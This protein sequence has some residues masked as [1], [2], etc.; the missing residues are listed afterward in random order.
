MAFSSAF[1]APVSIIPG[2]SFSSAFDAAVDI[3]PGTSFS[4]AFDA[5]V[6]IKVAGLRA[7]QVATDTLTA[8]QVARVFAAD[9]YDATNVGNLFATDSFTS[10]NVTA[11]FATDSITITEIDTTGFILTDGSNAFAAAQSMGGFKLTNL[12]TPTADTDAV[13]KAYADSIAAGFDPKASVR[14]STL[15]D[16]SGTYSAV[17]GTGGTGAF[18]NVDFTSGTIFDLNGNT[19]AIGDRILVKTQS[20]AT[21]NG[22][23][24]VTTAGATGAMERASDQD[25]SPAGEVSSGN[26]TFVELGATYAG[27]GWVLLG[28]G[29]LTLNTDNLSWSQTSA[30]GSFTGG[31]GIDITGSTISVDLEAAGAGTGG[32]AFD[33]GQLRVDVGNG[34]ELAAGGVTV[35]PDST[36]GG[37][38]APVTVAANGVGVD[39]TTLDGDHLTVDYTPTNYTP[40][41]TPAEAADVDD[42]A[43]HLDG[44]NTVLGTIAGGTPTQEEVTTQNIT[45]TDTAITDTLNS[46]PISNSSVVLFLNGQQL[47]QGAG[48]D[49]TISGAT[50]TWLASSGSAPDLDTTDTLVAFYEV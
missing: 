25:G 31:N 18:T 40:S 27:S 42:L 10:G 32:L 8:S 11:L 7:K 41:A 4:S 20:S 26:F 38:T 45:G 39:V 30:A 23:Y 15:L 44:I 3:I 35:T 36:T 33:A 24:E 22:I 29:I 37:D 28:D 9:A 50:I 17:G 21:E 6:E 48:N 13:T 49:Y 43:A 5:E 47:V 16:V 2:T 12:G 14:F 1:D 46:T 19:V 34:L